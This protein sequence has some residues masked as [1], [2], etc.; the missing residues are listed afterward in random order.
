M[1]IKKEK[2]GMKELRRNNKKNISNNKRVK[3]M[4]G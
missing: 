2:K 3:M 1:R 4:K